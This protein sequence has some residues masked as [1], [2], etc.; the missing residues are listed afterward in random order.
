MQVGDLVYLDRT[1]FYEWN[2]HI[3]VIISIH[4]TELEDPMCKVV[5][6]DGAE[7]ALNTEGIFW[8]CMSELEVIS[9]SRRFG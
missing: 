5:W 1:Q 8:A 6:L 3:G 9:E 2:E 7:R 4:N